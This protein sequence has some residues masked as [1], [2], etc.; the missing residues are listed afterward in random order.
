MSRTF[1]ESAVKIYYVILKY[2]TKTFVMPVN[3]Y[4]TLERIFRKPIPTDIRW[5]DTVAILS[6][7]GVE[8][9]QR[10][11]SHVLPKKVAERMVIHRPHPK[12]EIGR[13]TVRYI[14]AFLE[15]AGVKP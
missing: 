14:A 3:H 5:E 6:A 13:P 8:V 1:R 4:R 11:G 10:E 2:G 9:D 12:P 15:T 7:A